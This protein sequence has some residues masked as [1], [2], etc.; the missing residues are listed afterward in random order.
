MY[1]DYKIYFN[2]SFVLVT[3]ERTQMNKNFATILGSEKETKHFFKKPAALFDGVTNGNILALTEKPGN[4]ICDFMDHINLVMAGGGIVTNEKD[5]LLLIFRRGKWDLP[6]G[7]IEVNE[8][9]MDG[10]KREVEEETGVRIES[11]DKKPIIT[12]HAYRLRGKDSL[13]ET[14]WFEMKALPGQTNLT[15]QTEEDIDEV[16][17][18]SKA[19][20]KNYKDGC[21]LLIWDLIS[22]YQN[23]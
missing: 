15:P 10:A 12:Y 5:E 8:K 2:D 3:K 9:I 14:H 4:V 23:A 1:Q 11:V 16:R 20:L 13:K 6:K 17:W 7:K 18:V 22:R 19:D 21:F